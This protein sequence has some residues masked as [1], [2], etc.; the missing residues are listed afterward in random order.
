V[1]SSSAERLS[2]WA[3]RRNT[4][5]ATTPQPT[6]GGPPGETPSPFSPKGEK[7]YR[8][9]P[10]KGRTP[11]VPYSAWLT[12]ERALDL[13]RLSFRLRAE[14]ARAGADPAAV[15]VEA[16]YPRLS[17]L[18]A[19]DWRDLRRPSP[20]SLARIGDAAGLAPGVIADIVQ[21]YPNAISEE[22]PR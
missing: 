6:P 1:S 10:R 16:K 7:G 3:E 8:A 18:L 15:A 13:V 19:L 17:N 2:R 4:P 21:A 20:S 22:K 11:R 9:N 14:M 12:E 5:A